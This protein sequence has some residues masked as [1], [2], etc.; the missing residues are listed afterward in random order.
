MEITKVSIVEHEHMAEME[1]DLK[2]KLKELQRRDLG[3]IDSIKTTIL[4]LVVSD[5]YDHAKDELRAYIQIKTEYPAFQGRAERYAEHCCELIQA[6][7]TKRN[8]PGLANLALAK[9]QDMHEKILV[10]FEELKRN[11]T[12]IEKIE[13][14]QKLLDMRST[15]WILRSACVTV[16]AIVVMAFFLDLQ[17]GLFSSLFLVGEVTLDNA[18]TWL[19]QLVGFS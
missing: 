18:T 10:H 6:I 15:V 7:K 4:N 1:E 5:A 12:Q 11:L 16:A 14:E 19:V 17:A 13:R 2:R 8:F 3:Q 9:Q